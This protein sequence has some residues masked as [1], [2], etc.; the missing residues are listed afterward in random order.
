M[1]DEDKIC[2]GNY[3]NPIRIECWHYETNKKHK[4]IGH[5]EIT[6]DKIKS[7]DT[8]FTL[9]DAKKDR[10]AGTL[11]LIKFTIEETHPSFIDYIRGGEQLSAIVAIDFTYSNKPPEDPTSL[12]AKLPNGLLNEYQ[13]AISAVCQLI[14]NY[15]YDQ[16]IPVF[17]FGAWLKYDTLPKDNSH[18]FPCSGTLEQ[19]QVLGVPGIM[20]VYQHALDHLDLSMPTYFAPVLNEL[21]K[22]C[23]INVQNKVE[24]YSVLLILTDGDLQN[25]DAITQ[26]LSKASCLPISIIIIGIGEEDFS[27]V[28]KLQNEKF[29]VNSN[30]KVYYRNFIQFV[31]FKK[32]KNEMGLLAKHV[33]A[34]IPKQLVE[35]KMLI[36]KRPNAPIY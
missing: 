22:A 10:S 17:G 5:A 11:R 28:E 26:A 12:H 6:I 24:V 8:S 4:L 14:L 30:G 19:T 27:D 33:L 1:V 23:E 18:C 7:G 36:G 21:I 13:Q 25:V 15:D 34:G 3:A 35:Y 2:G 20:G 29:L 9:L 16:M 31:P 32:F